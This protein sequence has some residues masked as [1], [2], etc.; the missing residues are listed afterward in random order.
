EVNDRPLGMVL[1]PDGSRLAVVTGSNFAPRALHILDA[2]R[3]ALLGTVPI[4]N[5]FVGVAFSPDGRRL[6]VGGGASD[7]VIV[8]GERADGKFER[9]DK[10]PI[11]GGAPSGLSLSPDGSTLYVALN[12]KHSAAVINLSTREVA[13]IPVGMHPYTTAVAPSGKKVY[14]SNWAGRKARPGDVTD[15]LYRIVVDPRT[16]IPNTGTLSVI[17]TETRTVVRE[18]EVGLHPSAMVLNPGGTRLFVANANSDT[19]SVIDTRTD[20]VVSS[21]NVRPG[22]RAPIGSAPN[23]L[24]VSPGG[25]TLYVANGA[26]NAV[27]VVDIRSSPERVLGFLPSGW[28][29]TALAAAGDGKRL[30]VASGYGFGSVAP[31]ASGGSGRSYRDR[32]GVV[33]LVEIPNREGL[34][35]STAQ[36]MANNRLAGPRITPGSGHPVPMHAGRASPI[37]HV[38]YIIKENRTYD[39]VFGD[40]PQGNGDPSLVQFGREVSPNHHAIAGQFVLLDNFYTPA[41]QSA[42]GHR[43]CTQGYAS[44]WIF[45]YGNARNDANPMLYAPND[46][47]W[48]TAKAHGI[49]VRSYGERGV[50]TITPASASFMDIYQGWKSGNMTVTIKP[51]TFVRGLMDIYH[52]DYPAFGGKIPD[53][54]RADIF[55]R[56][57]RQFEKSGDLPRLVILLLPNDH[58]N[59]TAPGLPTPRAS[60]ADNDL[61]LGRIVEAISKSRYW[62]ESAIFVVED[63]AQN[64]LDHVAGHRTVALL[65]SP[66]VRRKAVDSSFY[67]TINLYRTIEQI[68]G[69]P[70]QNQF[71]LAA[72]P[73]FSCFTGKP[74]FTPYT[75]LPNNIPLDELNPPLRGLKGQALRDAVASMR[76]DFSEPDAVPEQ[77]L[78]RIVWRATRGMATPYPRLRDAER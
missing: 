27:A 26:N 10:F 38:F 44:D 18:V 19:V 25:E 48:D 32:A 24:A 15:E 22:V 31:P 45:K 23:A 16:G 21:I 77:A 57:F 29:P 11:P 55:L 30:W 73:M 69:L 54:Y 3:A 6:Y 66:W 62:K 17:D 36:V 74:D 72:E 76:M 12:L 61:A 49:S 35:R 33:S 64:G 9:M 53:Q 8:L 4:G 71:D 39:Q 51:R 52:P 67:T 65:I 75:A 58:T 78:N 37:R 1:S 60:V 13:Q 5:S 28:Y 56:E 46:F 2:R 7:E 42:L 70:P 40:L 47:L 20:A 59:G 50:N 34:R 41:D 63:D 43:W 14:V 68:L